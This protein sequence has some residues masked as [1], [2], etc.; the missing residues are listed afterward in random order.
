MIPRESYQAEDEGF[1]LEVIKISRPSINHGKK[2]DGA[3][4]VNIQA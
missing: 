2:M 4:T 1:W 3:L